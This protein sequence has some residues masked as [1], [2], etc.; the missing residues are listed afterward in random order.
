MNAAAAAVVSILH[1]S[2]LTER[3]YRDLRQRNE[4]APSRMETAVMPM[5]NRFLPSSF[6]AIG[7]VPFTFF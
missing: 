2:W 3:K 7:K 4:A 6:G 5:F 1:R